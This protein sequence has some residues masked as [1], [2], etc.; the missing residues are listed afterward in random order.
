MLTIFRRHTNQ[1]LERHGRR[2]PGR[3]YRRCLCPIHA[4]GHLGGVMYRRALETT[5]WTRAQDLVREREARGVWHDPNEK[6]PVT[7]VEAV[8]S[9][10]QTL[11]AKSTGKASST[12]RHLRSMFIGVNAEW[13]LQTK[14]QISEGLL[15]SCRSKGLTTVDELTVPVLTEY[16]AA[17]S[18]GPVHRGK[19][20]QLLRRFFRFCIAAGWLEKNPAI[21]LEYPQGRA[22]SVRPKQ[23]FDAPYLPQ[24]GPEWKAILEQVSSEPKLLAVTLLMRRA[25]LRISDATTLH[26]NRLMAD[27]SIFLFMSKTN[28][29]VSVP[30]HPEL[31]AA[32]GAIQPNSAGYYFWSGQSAVTT[33][34]DNWRRRFEKA[35]Q[36]AGIVGG[37]PHRLRHT[38]AVD[39]LLRGVPIDQVSVLLGH[40]SVKV[41]ERHYLA[42]VAAR[43]EQIADSL[44][45]AWANGTTAE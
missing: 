25:G 19:R 12:T 35:F 14:R 37:H 24:E 27:G 29:P 2:D 13:A 11:S 30:V 6:K 40:S 34:T 28:E 33:A 8:T 44:R 1:C 45:R 38:F 23:P 7:I 18:C 22:I 36:R 3:K 16:A 15:D 5:S 9:F 21:A 42:F 10:L 43:R 32:L 41:T 26:R 31:K 20:I 4:E 17:W 39:L